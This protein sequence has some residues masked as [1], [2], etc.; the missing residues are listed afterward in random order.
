MMAFSEL[1][2]VFTHLARLVSYPCQMVSLRSEQRRQ[3]DQGI[4]GRAV[5]CLLNRRDPPPNHYCALSLSRHHHI[6]L[7]HRQ[8]A[9]TLCCPRSFSYPTG[10]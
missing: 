3:I 9:T 8:S 1:R 10:A 6:A 2:W 7:Q 4:V 5:L